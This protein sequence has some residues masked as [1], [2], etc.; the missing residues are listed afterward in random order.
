GVAHD[1][2]FLPE[3]SSVIGEAIEVGE[4]IELCLV[5]NDRRMSGYDARLL[6]PRLVPSLARFAL[7]FMKPSRRTGRINQGDVGHD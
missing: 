1:S 5:E 7:R 6:R 3:S 2:N 4:L